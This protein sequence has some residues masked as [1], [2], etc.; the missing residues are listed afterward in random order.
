MVMV[1]ISRLVI[2]PRREL[3]LS[4]LDRHGLA[5][6]SF[7]LEKLGYSATPRPVAISFVAKGLGLS[8]DQVRY[9]IDQL[10]E[11]KVIEKW[12]VKHPTQYKKSFY[13]MVYAGD[14]RVLYRHRGT[15]LP[16]PAESTG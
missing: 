4:M 3:S 9:R 2:R 14:R 7:F 16:L 11:G 6:Y 5:V 1:P 12:T 10:V 13:R 15:P 8:V